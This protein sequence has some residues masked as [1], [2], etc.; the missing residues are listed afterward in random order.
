MKNEKKSYASPK[1]MQLGSIG[2]ITQGAN[3]DGSGGLGL[4]QGNP[5]AHGGNPNANYHAKK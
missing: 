2:Q 1:L 4:G 5:N 3:N